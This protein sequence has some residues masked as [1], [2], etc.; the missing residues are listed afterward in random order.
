MKEFLQLQMKK[1]DALMNFF[2]AAYFCIGLML[3]PYYNTWDVALGVGS[4]CLL[5]YY[6]TRYFMP[7]SSLY[8]YVLAAVVGVFMAQFIYQMHGLFEMH[9]FAFIGSVILISYRNWKLQLPLAAVVII[10][11]AVFGYLQFS[12]RWDI[13]LTQLDYM[14]LQTFFIHIALTVVIFFLSGYWAYHIKKSSDVIVKKS[15]AIGKLQEAS[16]QKDT[17]IAMSDNLKI[18][19]DKLLSINSE[20]QHIFNTVKEVLFSMDYSTCRVIQVSAACTQVF[21]YTPGQFKEDAKLWLRLIYPADKHVVIEME[22]AVKTGKVYTSRY[23]VLHKNKDIRWVE[24]RITPTLDASG[25]PERIDGTC[26]DITEEVILKQRLEDERSQHIQ[27]VTAAVITAQE[28]ERSFLSGELHDNINP[29]LATAKLYLEC[30]ASGFENRDE[31]LAESKRFINTAMEEIR[32]L[33]R[34]LSA[35]TLGHIS[36]SEAIS[37]LILHI[38]RTKDI[39]FSK[40]FA[41]VNEL[42]LNDKL[43]L[44]IYRIVQEQ[45]NNI[46]RHAQATEVHISLVQHTDKLVL[47]VRD[48]GKGCTITDKPKGLGLQNIASRAGLFDGEVS[49]Q[50]APGKGFDLIV[51]FKLQYNLCMNDSKAYIPVG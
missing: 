29:V 46:I 30:V 45:V 19:N 4:L 22:H 41:G 26:V 28:N 32:T 25:R 23:R 7:D 47:K 35:P 9:F 14:S 11:H 31:L 36:L 43:K 1:V 18:S 34:A 20:L 12:G 16:Q 44:S 42:L 21:G 51:S 38:E 5:A 24:T 2:L 17:L 40:H 10:H 49:M 48:N 27:Q 15:Y 6:S 13:Y 3:A 39:R 37:N 8:R 50:S 33:S